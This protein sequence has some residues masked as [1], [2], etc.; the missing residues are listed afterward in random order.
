ML[1]AEPYS[2]ERS[3]NGFQ[4]GASV[5]AAQKTSE[6][7]ADLRS[8]LHHI[9][10][11]SFAFHL[12]NRFRRERTPRP[13][14]AVV[15]SSDDI[16]TPVDAVGLGVWSAPTQNTSRPRPVT[17]HET[18]ISYCLS[19]GY[20]S[21]PAWDSSTMPNQPPQGIMTQTY[22]VQQ[23]FY[24]PSGGANRTKLFRSSC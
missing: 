19:E 16:S 3:Q 13:H 23:D 6:Y 22:S 8:R 15:M 1:V 2:K 9:Q 10:A 7:I 18:G 21:L 17:I 4:Q 24:T 12:N 11:P 14:T 5:D 20:N